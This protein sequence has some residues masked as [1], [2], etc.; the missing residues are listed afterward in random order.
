[1]R[2]AAALAVIFVAA[3]HLGF[4]ALE[5]FFWQAPL[6]LRISRL[7]RGVLREDAD[8]DRELLDVL[9]RS[10]APAPSAVPSP[11]L[12]ATRAWCA[13]SPRRGPEGMAESG[14]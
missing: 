2:I 1:M 9:G 13:P 3:L 7:A 12:D 11:A 8:A 5:M 10:A 4:L 14:V 6:G